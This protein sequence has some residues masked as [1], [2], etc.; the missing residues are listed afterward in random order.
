MNAPAPSRKL[1]MTRD[2]PERLHES[3]FLRG[4]LL[5]H[6]LTDI[7]AMDNDAPTLVDP[8]GKGARQQARHGAEGVAARTRREACPIDDEA[9]LQRHTVIER[10][11][12]DIDPGCDRLQQE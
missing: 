9:G 6:R 7:E 10:P 4:I 12:C 3:R 11:P 5:G 2:A 1:L 8:A